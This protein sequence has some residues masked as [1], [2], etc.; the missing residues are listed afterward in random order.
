MQRAVPFLQVAPEVGAIG[1]T[2]IGETAPPTTRTGRRTSLLRRGGTASCH[3]HRIPGSQYFALLVWMSLLLAQYGIVR[4][5][6][7]LGVPHDCAFQDDVVKLMADFQQ[8]FLSGFVLAIYTGVHWPDRFQYIFLFSWPFPRGVF[9]LLLFA[10]SGVGWG[11]LD[12]VPG[13]GQ[14]SLTGFSPANTVLLIATAVGAIFLVAW[15]VYTAFKHNSRSGF[16]A[17][18]GSRLILAVFYAGYLVAKLANQDL[19]FH[20]HHYMV[21]F[22]AASLAEFNHPFSLMLLAIATGIFVQGIAAYDADAI[23]SH[24]KYYIR[25]EGDNGEIQS[26][27]WIS[28]EASDFF[29][30]HC[31]FHS[32][33]PA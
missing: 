13:L 11:L 30:A 10:A 31:S 12:L 5:V 32:D 9:F 1:P 7:T 28:K 21:A 17:Y 14:F 27:P 6:C 8:L 20:F 3:G 33:M 26:S 16:A 15:H 22:L 18:I 25:F 29:M 19:S 24:Q 2:A 23:I 4:A